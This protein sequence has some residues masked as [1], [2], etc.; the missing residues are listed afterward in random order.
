VNFSGHF[1]ADIL[2][3]LRTKN[4]LRTIFGI[5]PGTV[6]PCSSG[7]IVIEK[8]SISAPKFAIRQRLEM[9]ELRSSEPDSA[10]RKERKSHS[11]MKGAANH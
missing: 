10:T 4:P 1:V 3:R 5:R 11:R 8:A 6:K 7:P 9:L 2:T